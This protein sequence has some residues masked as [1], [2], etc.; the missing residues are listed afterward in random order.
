MSDQVVVLPVFYD[1]QA[2]VASDRL[3]GVPP[4][5]AQGKSATWNAHEWDVL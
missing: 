1:V 2:T 3:R 5:V 4:H